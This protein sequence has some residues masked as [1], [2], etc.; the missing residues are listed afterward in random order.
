M[1]CVLLLTLFAVVS[2]DRLPRSCGTC[3]PSKCAPLPAE[4]CSSGT[5]LDAC[6]CCELCA[7]GDG[8]PCG[9]RGASAKRCASGLECVKSDKDKKSKSGVCVCKSNYPVCGTD[10]V[11]YNSGCELKAASVKAVKD[12]KPEIKIRNKGKC[13]QA[14]VIVTAPGEVWNVTG[15]QVFL[16]C[17]ATGIPTPVLTWRKVYNSKDK[18]L[19]LPGDKDNLAVQTR[20]GPEK[21]EVT[22]WVLISPL[23]KEEDGSYECH[24][25]NIQGEAS[26]V[27]TIHVVDSINDIPPKKGK[28][29]EL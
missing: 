18:T 3:D 29:D 12:K 1:I 24:A 28:D 6:G 17:E 25:S 27:G 9:G 16:S 5:L 14:P 7:S 19:P 10:G 20:G 15:S 21:H 4:G 26:A 22:G 8:E 11:N 2:A 23:T 13:A